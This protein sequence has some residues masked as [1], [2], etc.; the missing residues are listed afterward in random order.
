MATLTLNFPVGTVPTAVSLTALMGLPAATTSLPV[1][2]SGPTTLTTGG[3]QWVATFAGGATDYAYIATATIGGQASSFTGWVA[4]DGAVS[5]QI[6]DSGS[7][8]LFLGA[9]NLTVLSNQNS[10]ATTPNS[11]AIGQAIAAAESRVI[12]TLATP[13]CRSGTFFTIPFTVGG[14]PI[15]QAASSVALPLLQAAAQQYAGFLLN[16]WRVLQSVPADE[17]QLPGI[18]RVGRAWEKDADEQLQRIV[19]WAEGYTR[20]GQYVDL[21]LNEGAVVGHIYRK[22][23]APIFGH[24]TVG[25]DGLP[26]RRVSDLSPWPMM[27][28]LPCGW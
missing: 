16:R 9:N 26:I 18:F 15:K 20:T 4:G 13:Q 3:N 23:K 5:G 17:S 19:R 2:F 11:G 1:A 6:I 14:T 22:V 12:S 28:P 10:A 27:F 21:D 24:Q 7:L 8:S 25:P